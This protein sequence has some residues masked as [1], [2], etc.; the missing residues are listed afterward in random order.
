MA[1]FPHSGKLPSSP[2]QFPA[3]PSGN[4]INSFLRFIMWLSPFNILLHCATQYQSL[5]VPRKKQA[6]GW[7]PSSL[8]YIT[9]FHRIPLWLSHCL[10]IQQFYLKHSLQYLITAEHWSHFTLLFHLAYKVQL[11][12]RKRKYRNWEKGSSPAFP[13]LPVRRPMLHLPVS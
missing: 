11:K 3:F 8:A 6:L 1:P 13:P 4:P 5:L 7:A 2:E 9:S 10:F 12:W